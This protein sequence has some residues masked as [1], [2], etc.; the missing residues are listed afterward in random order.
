VNEWH[1]K[2]V[3]AQN[4]GNHCGGFIAS[5]GVTIEILKA[6]VI[7][8]DLDSEKVRRLTDCDSQGIRRSNEL[9]HVLRI[10]E[11]RC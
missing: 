5:L 6:V 7:T 1:T 11:G 10:F 2:Q 9:I 8:F 4:G 3:I